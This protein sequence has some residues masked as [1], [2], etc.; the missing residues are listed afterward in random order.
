MTDPA[1]DAAVNVI[2]AIN[3]LEAARP[4]APAAVHTQ[5]D[6]WRTVWRRRGAAD[7]GGRPDQAVGA[8]RDVKLAA[9]GYCRLYSRLYGLSTISLRYG[10]VYGPRQDIRG[11]AGVVA[12]FCGKLVDGGAPTV[13]GDGRQT[14]DWVEVSD[15]VNANLLALGGDL[16]GAI[17]IGHG[18]ET[19]VLDLL[20]A[21][22]EVG[23]ARGWPCPRR[24][25]RPLGSARF[26]GAAS[27]SRGPRTSS[28]G[29]RT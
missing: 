25:S 21:L 14:R 28:A 23:A 8:V 10:N 22:R 29:S 19:S 18:R 15:V 2:G 1:A 6:R 12:V 26:S 24:N 5:L 3:V 4:M 9:E 27:T 16:G 13:F 20:D 11:E 7:P 17:N